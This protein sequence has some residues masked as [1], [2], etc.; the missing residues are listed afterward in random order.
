MAKVLSLW[1]YFLP[2]MVAVGLWLLPTP[3]GLSPLSWLYFSIFMG[4]VLGLIIEPVPASFVAVIGVVLCVLLRIGP[5]TQQV[6]PGEAINWGL[7]GFANKTVW[8]VFIAFMLGL[9]YEKSGLGKRIALWLIALLG[10]TTL[11]LGYAVALADL[12]LA[13]FI[14]S[15]KPIK[16]Y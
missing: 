6:S 3:E 15:Y 13:P 14:R 8:L 12:I 11:G 1:R 4:M 9:G 16:S 2:V 5:S 7:S 10:K